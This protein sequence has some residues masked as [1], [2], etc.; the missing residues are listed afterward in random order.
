[1]APGVL[2]T[3]KNFCQLPFKFSEDNIFKKINKTSNKEIILSDD[4]FWYMFLAIA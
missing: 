3:R 2:L 4:L 1:M